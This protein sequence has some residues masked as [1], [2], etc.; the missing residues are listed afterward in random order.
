MFTAL[1]VGMASQVYGHLQNHLVYI[2]CVQLFVY[3][4][5]LSKVAYKNKSC[6]GNSELGNCHS[7]IN[8]ALWL[9][10]TV[11]LL[12]SFLKKLLSRCFPCIYLI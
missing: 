1:I 5:C 9:P 12:L 4:V 6:L 7:I 8:S 11:Y 3:Q 2:K 10:V